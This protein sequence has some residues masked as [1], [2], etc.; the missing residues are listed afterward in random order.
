MGNKFVFGTAN[1]SSK[2]GIFDKKLSHLKPVSMCLKNSNINFLDTAIDYCNSDLIKKYFPNFCLDTKIRS[3]TCVSLENLVTAIEQHISDLGSTCIRTL[4]IHDPWNIKEEQ[5][6]VILQN[7]S[8]LK[9]L[10]YVQEIGLSLYWD[11]LV[12][13]WWLFD[14]VQLP[15]SIYHGEKYDELVAFSKEVKVTV[16]N[17]FLQG[18]ILK[19]NDS[20]NSRLTPGHNLKSHSI[21][22][23]LA[24]QNLSE[25]T[26]IVIGADDL[27]QLKDILNAEISTEMNIYN[28]PIN[29][30]DPRKW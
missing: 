17:V 5:F 19:K 9:K 14:R 25:I 3:S 10:K 6:Q 16:R 28:Y 30:L 20:N 22:E 15:F 13:K 4:Y 11:N 18:I 7:I 8:H 21:S 24:I 27:I 23:C 2:Y 12:N 29:A 1:L 26:N